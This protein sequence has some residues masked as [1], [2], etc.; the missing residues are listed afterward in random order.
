[1]GTDHDHSHGGGGHNHGSA[2]ARSGEAAKRPLTLA[3]GLSLLTF[4]VQVVVGALTGSLALLTDS[5][6]VLTDGVGI[7][8][9]LAAVILATRSRR[10]ERTFGLYRLEVLS[11]LA[12]AVLLLAVAAWALYEA[13]QRIQDPP[14]VPGLPV[15]VVGV[16]GL[17]TNLV[18]L[19]LLSEGG[20]LAAEGARLE[21]LADTVGSVGVVAGGAIIIVTGATVVDAWVG[22]AIALWIV[23]RSLRLAASA[24]RVLVQ[25]A[26]T[27]LDLDA[28]HDDLAAIPDVVGIHD[29]H[30]WTLTSDMEVFTAHVMVS[31]DA[32]HHS[33]LDQARVLLADRHGIHHATLQVEPEDHQGCDELDW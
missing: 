21:V 12:N 25:A 26:P 14:E 32:D 19:R 20:S 10:P 2:L 16:V 9:A 15:L 29:L 27:G 18:A 24:L 31:T 33:V 22:L 11:A 23:P 1:M 28:I 13:V 3:L 17:I 8:L 7:A 4:V 6:H 30:L 5:A